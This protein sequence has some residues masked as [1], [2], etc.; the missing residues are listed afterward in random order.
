MFAGR[1]TARERILGR[2]LII[3]SS[4]VALLG[5]VWEFLPT[6]WIRLLKGRYPKAKPRSDEAW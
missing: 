5:P 3:V 1:L 2:L 6:C 4:V